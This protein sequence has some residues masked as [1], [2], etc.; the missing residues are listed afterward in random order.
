MAVL[1]EHFPSGIVG[2]VTVLLSNDDMQFGSLDSFLPIRNLSKTLEQQGETLQLADVRSL[3]FPF[4]MTPYGK[5]ILASYAVSAPPASGLAVGHESFVRYV[6]TAPG[7]ARHVTRFDVVSRI[8]P[9]SQ[10]S[11]GN[12][13]KLEDS[14]QNALTGKLNNSQLD[15]AGPS[16][17]LRD[18]ADVTSADFQMIQ[19][20][21]PLVVFV[22]LILLLRKVAVSLYL[23]ASVVFSFL[24]TL[25]VTYLV[26]WHSNPDEFIGL[27][28]KVPVFLFTILVAVG[29]DYNIFLLTRIREEEKDHG[30]IGGVTTALVKTGGVISSCGF[31]MAGTF[32]ALLAGSLVETKQLGFSLA[33]GVLLD[34]LVVRP[35]LVPAFLIWTRRG[36]EDEVSHPLAKAA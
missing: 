14:F 11:I 35:I 27:D 17:G 34:T 6:S 30:P 3:A 15:F 26:F 2:P 1:K 12:L 9:L 8:D 25:G 31:I 36:Q 10:E 20:L 24:A 28:W 18:L 22:I 33:F 21:V 7:L 32:A 5:N 13:R 16:A 19:F 4:G 29:E 23:I